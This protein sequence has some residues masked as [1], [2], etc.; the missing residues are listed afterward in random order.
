[1]KAFF[2]SGNPLAIQPASPSN[3]CSSSGGAPGPSSR[4]LEAPKLLLSPLAVP[5]RSPWR[6]RRGEEAPEVYASWEANAAGHA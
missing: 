6:G 2:P 3:A 1:M 5:L 4:E